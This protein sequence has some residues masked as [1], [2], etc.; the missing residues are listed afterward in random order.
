MNTLAAYK[1]KVASRYIPIQPD[2]VGAK[3]TESD[4]YVTSTK[5]DGHLTFLVVKDGKAQLFDRKGTEIR[6]PQI[7]AVAQ[8]SLKNDGVFAGELCCF[9]DDKSTSHREVTSAL[10][11]PAGHDIRFGAF[12]ILEYNG[13]TVALDPKEKAEMLAKL[14]PIEGALF[15]VEQH[16][17]ESRKEIAELFRSVREQGAEG[18]VVRIPSGVTYKIKEIITLDLVVLGYAE[19][20]GDRKG[21]LRELLLGFALGEGQYQIVTKC[22]G[23]FTDVDR[24]ELLRML[25]QF[26][27]VS[28]YTEVSGA[29]TAFTF[30][31][32]DIVVEMTCL[33]LINE[34]TDGPIRKP[35]LEYESASGYTSRG[36][37]S[38]ISVISPNFVRIRS[39][40]QS[41]IE[42]AGPNQALALL[43]LVESG[44]EAVIEPASS[45]VRREVYTKSGKTGVAVRKF[46]G[47][48]TNKEHTGQYPPYV[49]VYTDFAGGR[50]TP[51]EQE[52]FLC[53]TESAVDTRF[54]L[55]RQ[56]N[57]K[58]GWELVA[59]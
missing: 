25:E 2:Q 19:A 18:L 21:M 24:T 20:I 26:A 45:I 37:A 34:T 15:A 32:P 40:K 50:K 12:D 53:S 17:Y 58:K 14:L 56:E 5:Y 27:V 41:S 22:G 38:G 16:C 59:D 11:K 51:L 52:I 29:K 48:K 8:A 9:V 31:K 39:D 35:F 33:D 3:I 44:T 28:E 7:S 6:L 10:A 23:G 1:A 4:Y 36:S 57:V 55:L 30:V 13:S 49:V 42:D 46:I 43:P 47:L 54:E